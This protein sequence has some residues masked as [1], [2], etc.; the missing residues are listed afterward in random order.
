MQQTI[1]HDLD[2]ATA[3]RVIERAFAEYAARFPDHH[4]YLRWVG[5]LRAEI[6]FKALGA[7]LSGTMELEPKRITVDLDVP[8]LLRPFRAKALA[9]IDEEVRRWV[10]K[11]H[12]SEL[13]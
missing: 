1:P 13:G 9:V 12:A 7:T 6:G 10:A 11:A 4:P 8:F 5:D 3:K 2:E